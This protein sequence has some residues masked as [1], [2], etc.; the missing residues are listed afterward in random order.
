MLN[1]LWTAEKWIGL[2]G[3]PDDADKWLTGFKRIASMIPDP[4][5][6]ASLGATCVFFLWWMLAEDVPERLGR[7]LGWIR[8][9]DRETL[10]RDFKQLSAAYQ[11]FESAKQSPRS[12]RTA[13]KIWNLSQKHVCLFEPVANDE[14]TLAVEFCI[15]ILET[16][17]DFTK[18]MEMIKERLKS[19]FITRLKANARSGPGTGSATLSVVKAPFHR[20]MLY[21]IRRMLGLLSIPPKERKR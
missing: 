9:A 13:A 2:A 16:E 1:A 18:A 15:G 20:M 19:P 14:R 4:L 5:G 6:W 12:T 8:T 17:D 11:E 21:K 10:L 3:L 7:K